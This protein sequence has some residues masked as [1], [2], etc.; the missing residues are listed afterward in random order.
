MR[1]P[2]IAQADLSPEQGP[3][4]EDMRAGIEKS[5]QGFKNIAE[6][7]ALLGTVKSLAA[8]TEVWKADLGTDQGA[9]H[10]RG[11]SASPT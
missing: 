5:F 2:L 11:R 6:N 3:I 10:H 8:R 7:G 4:Y 1:L 9:R